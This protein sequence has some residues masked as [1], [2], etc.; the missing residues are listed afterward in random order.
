[1]NLLTLEKNVLK[2][3][4]IN[5]RLKEDFGIHGHLVRTPLTDL[6]RRELPDARW[7]AQH[8]LGHSDR[9]MQEIYRSDI[10]ESGAVLA[11]H[12]RIGEVQAWR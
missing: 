3:G 11:M 4:F 9:N 10:A 1:M 6:V 8:M 12:Q 2:A 7:A 5:R